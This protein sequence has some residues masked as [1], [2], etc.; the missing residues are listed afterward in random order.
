MSNRYKRLSLPSPQP[1]EQ[2]YFDGQ[3]LHFPLEG[4]HNMD[5]PR[6]FVDVDD[7]LVTWLGGQEPHPY[8]HGAE[9]WE[10][11]DN[12]LYYMERWKSANPTGVI[13][14]WSGGGADY[15]TTWGN[16]ICPSL[17]SYSMGKM[18]ILFSPND[19]YIDDSP[20][21]AWISK[22]LDPKKLEKRP[23]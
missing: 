5:L 15:A 1:Y 23:E 6:L 22:C 11:N 9:T 13:I 17:M 2:P 19:T 7:T 4:F 21:Q 12:V 3:Y 16:R 18:P 20:Y 8:G 10:V 14:I